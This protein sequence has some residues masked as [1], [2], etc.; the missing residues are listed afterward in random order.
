MRGNRFAWLV[1]GLQDAISRYRAL[2]DGSRVPVWVG[3][4][5][6]LTAIVYSTLVFVLSFGGE[7]GAVA[8][9]SVIL[10]PV[11]FWLLSYAARIPSGADSPVERQVSPWIVSAL[12]FVL[13]LPLVWWN[14]R[15]APDMV[16][17]WEQATGRAPLHDWHPVMHTCLMGLAALVAKTVRGVALVQAGVFAFLLGRLYAAFGKYGYCRWA[18]A[19]VVVAAAANPLGMWLFCLLLKDSAFAL[20]GLAVT[21]CLIHVVETRGDWLS[22]WRIWVL[23]ICLMLTAFLRHNGFFYT[24]P[25][26]LLL[27]LAV[28]RRNVRKALLCMASTAAFCGGYLVVRGELTRQGTIQPRRYYQGFAESVGLPMCLMAECYMSNP[29]KTPD[30]VK[31]FLSSFGDRAFWEASYKGDFNSV[32]FRLKDPQIKICAVGKRRFFD[33]LWRTVKA[34]P[35]AA[36]KAFLH[37]TALAWAPFPDSARSC[38]FTPVKPRRHP[39]LKSLNWYREMMVRAP[40]GTLVTVPGSYLLLV[41]LAFCYGVMRK[42]IRVC[43]LALPLIGYQFGT[44]LLLTGMDYRFFF[45]TVLCGAAASLSMLSGSGRDAQ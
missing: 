3:W 22:G 23:S 30:D 20:A 4:V 19:A 18:S 39:L 42:G 12:V 5:L 24:V 40:W 33:M 17:Q 1:N 34:N 37:V 21:I 27:P 36:R 41:V 11:F 13:Y 44:M 35:R 14:M 32:K 15:T 8:L 2:N 31:E 28:A 6:I 26:I 45:I 38:S 7:F 25:L 29:A 9:P 43:V 16:G 10:A